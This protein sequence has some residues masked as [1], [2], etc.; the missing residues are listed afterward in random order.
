MTVAEVLARAGHPQVPVP[1]GRH[2]RDAVPEGDLGPLAVIVLHG[3]PATLRLMTVLAGSVTAL[4]AVVPASG[5]GAVP[6]MA[7]LL[8]SLRSRPARALPRRGA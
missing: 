6:L 3:W 7:A 5:A 8:W 4:A 1:G 2:R